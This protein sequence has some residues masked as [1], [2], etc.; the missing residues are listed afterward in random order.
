MDGAISFLFFLAIPS[1][2][3]WGVRAAMKR[4]DRLLLF[5]FVLAMVMSARAALHFAGLPPLRLG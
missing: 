3:F 5:I 2:Y 4:N 1:M